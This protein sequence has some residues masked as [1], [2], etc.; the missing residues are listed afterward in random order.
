ML[1]VVIAPLPWGVNEAIHRG[2][3][4]SLPCERFAF[5]RAPASFDDAVAAVEEA[6]R[7]AGER[8]VVVGHSMAGLVAL[9]HALHHPQGVAGLVL[10]GAPAGPTYVKDGLWQ[11]GHPK[12]AAY[13]DAVRADRA[14]RDMRAYVR[15][16]MRLSFHDAERFAPL[17]ADLAHARADRERMEAFFRDELPKLDLRERLREVAAPA[18]VVAGREDPL[19]TLRESEALARALPRGEVVVLEACGHFPWYERPEAFRRALEPFLG[20]I[21]A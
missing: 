1:P 14:S 13:M 17:E 6:R 3:A 5:A 10:I 15:A 12:H 2:L 11:P 21:K 8:A 9:A 18:L 16:L 7:A 4:A 20:A 19:C